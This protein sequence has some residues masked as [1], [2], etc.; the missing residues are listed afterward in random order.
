M[1]EEKIPHVQASSNSCFAPAGADTQDVPLTR[2]IKDALKKWR[3]FYRL[4]NGGRALKAGVSGVLNGKRGSIDH[5][6]STFSFLIGA[7][8]IQ[9]RPMNITIEPV[10]VCNLR[11]PVCETGAGQ[12]GRTPKHLSLDEF[13]TIIDK[14]ASHTNTLMLYFMGEPFINKNIYEMIRYA[15]SREIPHVMTCTNGDFVEVEKVVDSGLDEISFQ[16][17][18]VTQETH[19]TYRV[20]SNLKRVLENL[21]QTVLV[22]NE[23]KVKMKICA[24]FILMKHNETQVDEF[25][26][27][28]LDIG[29]DEP[30]IIDPCVRTQEEGLRYL[31]TDKS[32][33]FYDPAAFIKG[34]LKPRYVPPNECPWIYYSMSIHVNG[35]VVPC[36]RDPLGNHSMGNL[37]TQSL[38][39]IWNGE[40]Y[41][42][43][44]KKLH[45]DQS[46]ID[47]CRLCSAYPPSL[48]K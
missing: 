34:I 43:F 16:I 4:L 27:L 32:H 37:L 25:K 35:S 9:G 29:V 8:R 33:W 11:C 31:P 13:K 14:V 28:M 3:S 39:E 6:K 17:G 48:I 2:W 20:N 46:Q 26:K 30:V 18:G 23:K 42:A 5:I 1:E 36:C 21:R 7:E 40:K 15:K 24:G 12:L 45:K 44:R 22:R 10:N 38:D 19:E 41:R 47:I